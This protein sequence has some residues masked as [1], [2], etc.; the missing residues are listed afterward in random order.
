MR[1]R[2][3]EI[4]GTCAK[5]KHVCQS[6]ILDLDYHL[7]VQ[8]RD[9]VLGVKESVPKNE[10][11]REYFIAAN[12]ERIARGDAF[13]LDYDKSVDPA[14]K[15]ILANVAEKR[16]QQRKAGPLERNLAPPCSFYAKGTCNRGEACPY[17][18]VLVAERYASLQSYRDRYYGENDP[19]AEKILEK[20]PALAAIVPASNPENNPA[21]SAQTRTVLFVQGIRGGLGKDDV[22]EFFNLYCPP[23]TTVKE[24]KMV[25]DGTAALVSFPNRKTAESVADQTIGVIDISGVT[26]NV[27]WSTKKLVEEEKNK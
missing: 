22:E 10:V 12:A 3:T 19:E 20:N 14:A 27:T 8:I 5:L 21:A 7:P 9:G 15:S 16:K 6:C 26:V 11:N 23:E 25:A 4:C 24:V 13:L 17:R 18:H 1:F 2:R